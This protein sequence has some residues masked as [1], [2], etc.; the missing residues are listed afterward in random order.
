M[1]CPEYKFQSKVTSLQTREKL[2]RR[3][4][5]SQTLERYHW[6]RTI[7]AI[8][9]S[10][11]GRGRESTRRPNFNQSGEAARSNERKRGRNES[12][13]KGAEMDGAEPSRIEKTQRRERS[14]LPPS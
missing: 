13:E 2:S 10:P 11:T 4:A 12:P 6:K 5:I 8:I 9:V 7:Y 3:K 1:K 14:T